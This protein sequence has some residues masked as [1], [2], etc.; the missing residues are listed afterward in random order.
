MDARVPFQDFE[1]PSLMF[2][3]GEDSRYHTVYD[4]YEYLDFKKA[5]RL[6][7]ICV[8]AVKRVAENNNYKKEI[9]LK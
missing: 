3:T 9:K 4:E 5:A 7:T 1:I 6:A 8:N 2:C